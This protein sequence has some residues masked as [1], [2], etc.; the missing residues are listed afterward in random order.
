MQQ[1]PENSY[2]QILKEEKEVVFITLSS[3]NSSL[4]SILQDIPQLIDDL[5]TF[6]SEFSVA[7][8]KNG[9]SFLLVHAPS[10][11]SYFGYQ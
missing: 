9:T 4:W 1:G 3:S 7:G 8:A 2:F 10:M 5:F 6:L 11:I